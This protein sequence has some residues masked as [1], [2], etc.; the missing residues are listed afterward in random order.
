M[1]QQAGKLKN[2]V[3]YSMV[4]YFLFFIIFQS[5][6][7]I[8]EAYKQDFNVNDKGILKTVHEFAFLYQMVN[9]RNKAT[10]I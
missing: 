4:L 7:R 6:F 3:R 10:L 9:K 2:V 8:K 5:K 1:Q